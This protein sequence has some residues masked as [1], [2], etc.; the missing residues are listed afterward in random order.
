MRIPFSGRSNAVHHMG[1]AGNQMTVSVT[2]KVLATVNAP[3]SEDLSAYQLASAISDI[4]VA[5]S[6]MGPTFSFFSEIP[7]DLQMGF[8]SEMGLSHHKVQQVANHLQSLCPFPLAFA[9]K[10]RPQTAL[11]GP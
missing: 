3:Y 5:Q 9:T 8:I 2:T 4:D 10:R 6:A 1:Q 11:T 7:L